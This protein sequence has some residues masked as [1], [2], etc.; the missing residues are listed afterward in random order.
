M[1]H[2]IPLLLF[3][4]TT[5]E[6]FGQQTIDATMQ[7]DGITRQYRLYIPAAYNGNTAVPLLFNLH[8]YGSNNLQ[9][10]IYG[11]FRGIADTAN[12]IICR[13]CKSLRG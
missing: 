13:C 4:L 2:L 6:V 1:K 5:M 7:H 9:Q 10:T 3:L 8:G 11:D 12:F